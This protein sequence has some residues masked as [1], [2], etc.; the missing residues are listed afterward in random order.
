VQ[1]EREGE[2]FRHGKIVSESSHFHALTSR[3]APGRIIGAYVGKAK[4]RFAFSRALLSSRT[5]LFSELHQ[6]DRHR[7]GKNF[8]VCTRA[9]RRAL[10]A[11]TFCKHCDC[12]RRARD[13][14]DKDFC[15][16]VRNA[17]VDHST[18]HGL[19]AKAIAVA[20]K[21]TDGACP[22]RGFLCSLYHCIGD[23]GSLTE[24]SMPQAFLVD[25]VSS[26]M[27]VSEAL[28]D[29]VDVR[30]RLVTA[31]QLPPSQPSHWIRES[32]K[33]GWRLV[34]FTDKALKHP[35]T[36]FAMEYLPGLTRHFTKS[37]RPSSK[38]LYIGA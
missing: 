28:L 30:L 1:R 10:S 16:A 38:V 12:L 32:F 37:S 4:R 18:E 27:E 19:S 34:L 24:K 6:V 21:L 15:Y 22:L 13:D 9:G 31:G 11:Q 8:A 25:L 23:A 36:K 29:V 3:S 35:V 7:A 33:S 17:I 14:P 5:R 26:R 20:Y 2:L